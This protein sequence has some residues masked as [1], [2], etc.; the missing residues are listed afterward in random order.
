MKKQSISI[1]FALFLIILISV[2]C[3]SAQVDYEVVI[4]E[5]VIYNFQEDFF[6]TWHYPKNNMYYTITS[7]TLEGYMTSDKTGFTARISEWKL[8]ENS[9]P[10][11]DEYPKG[12]AITATIEKMTG[13]WWIGI[14][15][16]YT[17]IW[18]MCTGKERIITGDGDTVYF[19]Q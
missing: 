6:G 11:R 7:E 18:Y 14:G 2:S 3:S 12:Y 10:N 8:I 5:E 17:W 1:L 15:D 9:E 4:V 19:R 16:T 13:G